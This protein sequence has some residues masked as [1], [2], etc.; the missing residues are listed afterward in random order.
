MNNNTF[1]LTG[2]CAHAVVKR[3]PDTDEDNIFSTVWR[4][5][6][7]Q[8]KFSLLPYLPIG[9]IKIMEP[10]KTLRDEFAMAA[11][12]GELSAQDGESIGV[13]GNDLGSMLEASKRY[14]AMADAMLEV[15]K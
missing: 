8:R 6:D 9:S 4:C 2:I 3:E 13:V 5:I 1:D 10:M 15:R 14:Y 11:M 7:C 12:Q